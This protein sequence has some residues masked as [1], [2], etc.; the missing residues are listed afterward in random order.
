MCV[1]RECCAGPD[2]YHGR[3]DTRVLGACDDGDHLHPLDEKRGP[4]IR[5]L[6]LLH[7]CLDLA[8][9]NVEEPRE[10]IGKNAVSTGS[11]PGGEEPITKALGWRAGKESE[12]NRRDRVLRLC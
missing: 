4:G 10:A 5:L 11:L 9:R 8:D 3:D 12:P 1:M 6:E 2:A 7:E